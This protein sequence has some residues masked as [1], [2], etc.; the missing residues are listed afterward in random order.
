MAGEMKPC[1]RPVDKDSFM[2]GVV[3]VLVSVDGAFEWSRRSAKRASVYVAT[4]TGDVRS[5]SV[6]IAAR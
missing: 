2:Q 4:P 3:N 5:N 6:T 1:I